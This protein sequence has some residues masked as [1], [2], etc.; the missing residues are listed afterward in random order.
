MRLLCRGAQERVEAQTAFSPQAP[1]FR[2]DLLAP[3]DKSEAP[4]PARAR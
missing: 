1:L 2:F 3:S 4:L